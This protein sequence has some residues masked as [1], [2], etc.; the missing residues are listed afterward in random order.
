MACTGSWDRKKGD[1]I[2]ITIAEVSN[3]LTFG[4]KVTCTPNSPTDPKGEFTRQ[5]LEQGVGWLL[6]AA[7]YDLIVF[8]VPKP[9]GPAVLKERVEFDGAVAHDHPDCTL[10]KNQS[11][12][13]EIRV[14]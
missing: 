2:R 4:M 1:R 12:D 11:C 8:V 13:F 7:T 9:G 3:A 14:H 6:T 10:Q 5:E